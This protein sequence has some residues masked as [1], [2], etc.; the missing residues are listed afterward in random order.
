MITL[1]YRKSDRLIVGTSHPRRTT[2]QTQ[3]AV[4]TEIGNICVSELGGVRDDYGTVEI[5]GMPSSGFEHV[6]GEDG[7]AST[8]RRKPTASER[9]YQRKSNKLLALG[10]TQEEIDA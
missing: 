9:A 5:E 3:Q 1:I 4:V 6:I 2:E 8:R 7:T 10:L